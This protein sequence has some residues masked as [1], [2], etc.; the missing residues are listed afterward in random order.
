MNNAIKRLE[1][2]G[3]I[4]RQKG[5]G[6]KKSVMNEDLEAEI[7]DLAQSQEENPGTHLSQRKLARSVNVSKST[8]H[9]TFKKHKLKNYKRMTC[10]QVNAGT[11]AR[12]LARSKKLLKRFPLWKF[13]KCVVQDESDFTLQV[14]TNR[15][16][17]RVYSRRKQGM[18]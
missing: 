15:Q 16:N 17:D 11:L 14:P 3:S 6:S 13:K 12:R 4:D 5:T 7:V 2:T 8:V 1:E 18:Y 9:R 10:P